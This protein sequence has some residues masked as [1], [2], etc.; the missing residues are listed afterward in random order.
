MNEPVPEPHP[1]PVERGWRRWLLVPGGGGEVPLRIQLLHAAA[2]LLVVSLLVS[3][4]LTRLA[5]YHWD[6]EVVWRYRAR[7]VQGWWLTVALSLCSLLLSSLLGLL[8]ALGQGSRWLPVR[9]AC[10]LY[11]ALVRGTPLLVQI[12]ILYYGLFEAAGLR[13]PFVA[14]VLILSLFT[15]AYISEMIR[16]GI[17]SVGRSQ[18]ESAMAVGFTPWQSYRHVIFP[19]A[20][21][22]ILP[23][24]AGQ[25]ASLVKD[26]SLLSVIAINEFTLAARDVSSLTYTA[27]ESYL[28]LALGYWALTLPIFQVARWLERRTGYET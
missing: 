15:G 13:Q 28:P 11:V 18:R 19:Q 27:F 6:W 14:G 25:F 17:E 9:S 4:T 23:P 3:F 24:L 21:R 7:F 2:A 22:Q 12:L 5:Y 26:S 1:L 10:R 16:A 8:A 20:L